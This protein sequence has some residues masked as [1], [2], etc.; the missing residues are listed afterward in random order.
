MVLVLDPLNDVALLRAG[1]IVLLFLELYVE[2]FMQFAQILGVLFAFTLL[3]QEIILQFVYLH[4][5]LMILVWQLLLRPHVS[6]LLLPV[7][8]HQT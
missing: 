8:Q 3:F 7:E 6:S 2:L 1:L 5:Q 4:L